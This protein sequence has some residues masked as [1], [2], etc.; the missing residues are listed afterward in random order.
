MLYRIGILAFALLW[1]G[2]DPQPEKS[3]QDTLLAQETKLIEAIKKKDLRTLRTMLSAQVYSITPDDGKETA[4]ES[5]RKLHSATIESY[6]VTDVKAIPLGKEAGILTYTFTWS[7]KIG[8]KKIPP[9]TVYAT[10]S[11]LKVDGEWK[12]K[13]YQETPFHTSPK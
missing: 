7:G 6:E 1:A 8:R 12:S 10:S 9:T 4:R 3:L 11:W 2:A 5:L 13:L